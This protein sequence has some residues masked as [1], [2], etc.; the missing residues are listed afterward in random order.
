MTSSEWLSPSWFPSQQRLTASHADAKLET[1][2]A[3]KRRMQQMPTPRYALRSSLHEPVSTRRAL[4][5]PY[6]TFHCQGQEWGTASH[7]PDPH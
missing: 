4:E 7:P 6:V 5:E 3:T 1:E 2:I